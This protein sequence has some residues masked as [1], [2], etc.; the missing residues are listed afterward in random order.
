VRLLIDT[1]AG[2]DDAQAII[3]ALADPRVSVEAVT[4]V[5]GNVHVDKVDRNVFTI[6]DLMAAHVP[7]FHGAEH[8]L[9]PGYWLPEERVHGP[10]GLGGYHNRPPTTLELEPEPAASALVRLANAAPGAYTLV[11][12]GPLTNIAL[13]CR[14]DPSFPH[15]IGRFVFMGGTI[16]GMGN[17]RQ[18]TAEFNFNCDPEAARET[19]AAFPEATMVSWETT[20]KHPFSW[21]QYNALAARDT[22]P[23]RFFCDTTQATAAFLHQLR[24]D[25]GY[26]L[27]DPLAMAIA[28]EPDLVQESQH[29]YVTVE[30]EGQH[31]RGQSVVDYFGLLGQVPNVHVVT[32]V[33]IDRVY[34]MFQD[35]LA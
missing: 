7:V 18:I 31:T 3:M 10:D 21:D 5:T 30:V 25:I 12:L 32:S 8:P 35:M 24:A 1:D 29:Y 9:V 20:L 14:L 2:V 33:D 19:L 22:A 4:T 17:T 27:P 23:G 28:L 34:E 11:A 6:L 15:K 26:L 13:A 16:S